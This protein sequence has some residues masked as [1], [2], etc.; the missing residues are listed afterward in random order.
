M[1]RN[2][3]AGG[4]PTRP[5]AVPGWLADR[6]PNAPQPR[7]ARNLPV[8]PDPDGVPDQVVLRHES[9]VGEA[10]VLAVV[11]VVTHEEIVAGRHHPI[12]VRRHP[13]RRQHDDVIA[14]AERLLLHLRQPETIAAG[15][16][17]LRD[18]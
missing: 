12:E 18:G 6:H 5:P 7:P 8:H 3:I 2:A 14:M 17:P 15:A 1:T 4:V 13:L 16:P 10:A 11:A 9:D